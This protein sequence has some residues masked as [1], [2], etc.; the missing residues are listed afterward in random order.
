MSGFGNQAFGTFSFGSPWTN[1]NVPNISDFTSF[2]YENMG[3]P[4]SA[5]P[6]NSQWPQFA[7]N[8]AMDLTPYYPQ[9]NALEYVLA[10]Y[11]C[12]AH[13]LLKITPDQPGVPSGILGGPA[14]LGYFA[15]LRGPSPYGFN[16]IGFLPGVV[17][18]SGDV[19]T[20]QSLL[21]ADFFKN[22]TINDLNFILTPWGREFLGYCQ[23]V[24]P[25]VW[26]LT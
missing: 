25:S 17:Q 8:R 3:V 9:V 23:D 2:I 5:L 7:F 20:N 1:P 6:L 11:N 21:V 18:A 19:S 26:G 14:N 10:V 15:T 13:V 24:G 22:L 12:G 4:V 16:L